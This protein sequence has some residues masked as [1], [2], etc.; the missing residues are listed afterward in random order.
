MPTPTR[1]NSTGT[2]RHTGTRIRL[3]PKPVP[4]IIR[5]AGQPTE[6]TSEPCNPA[7]P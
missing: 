3:T 6:Q 4:G 1:T 7:K 5:L 2:I